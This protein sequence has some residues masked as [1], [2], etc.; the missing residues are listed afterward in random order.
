MTPYGLERIEMPEI[1]VLRYNITGLETNAETEPGLVNIC[2][3]LEAEPQW[4][5]V[6]F[7]HSQSQI[8]YTLAEFSERVD[9]AI[10][11]FPRRVKI[12]YVF[13]PQ[14]FVVSARASKLLSSSGIQAQA[15]P[16][17]KDAL[18]YLVSTENWVRRA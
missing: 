17:A 16:N 6:L 13:N 3:R 4:T 10:K 12:A 18:D 11:H 9:Y 1:G 7:D 2:R 5:G 15:F 8:S 14:T